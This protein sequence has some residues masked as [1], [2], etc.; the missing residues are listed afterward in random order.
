MRVEAEPHAMDERCDR[1]IASLD[2][3]LSDG[4]SLQCRRKREELMKRS[5]MASGPTLVTEQR[6]ED[7]LIVTLDAV[8]G[9]H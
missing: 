2:R 1:S 5:K 3:T 7:P 8:V 4:P 6:S 9:K